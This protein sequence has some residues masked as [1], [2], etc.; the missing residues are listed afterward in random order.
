[1][2]IN[3]CDDNKVEMPCDCLPSPPDKPLP[4]VFPLFNTVATRFDGFSFYTHP[5]NPG[6]VGIGNGL[7]LPTYSGAYTNGAMSQNNW[8]HTIPIVIA[9]P[10]GYP[11]PGLVKAT[12]T[13]TVNATTGAVS[14]TMTNNGSGYTTT[15]A[16]NPVTHTYGNY[17]TT[18]NIR[19]A[20]ATSLGQPTAILANPL[21]IYPNLTLTSCKIIPQLCGWIENTLVGGSPITVNGKWYKNGVQIGNTLQ[22][23]ISIEGKHK[24]VHYCPVTTFSNTDILTYKIT[25]LDTELVNFTGNILYYIQL[26]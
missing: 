16:L 8:G 12:A 2:A 15:T 7:S 20:G 5:S 1:M 25:C 24:W 6:K 26:T 14:I 18:I 23:I 22:K 10:P 3:S 17:F 21:P 13:A 11:G 4:F 19:T 9:D